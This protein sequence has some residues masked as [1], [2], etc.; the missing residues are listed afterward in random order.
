MD[1][2]MHVCMYVCMCMYVYLYIQ[3][4]E[5][6]PITYIYVYIYMCVYIHIPIFLH[7]CMYVYIYVYIHTYDPGF[8][9]L[10]RVREVKSDNSH[11]F[12]AAAGRH[13]WLSLFLAGQGHDTRS[14]RHFGQ[15]R[16]AIFVTVVVSGRS[17][18]RSS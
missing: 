8:P 6:M 14:C 7:V 16:V 17:G 1:A 11:R 13:P 3:L 9:A 5:H 2:C 10:P 4:G 12:W 18:S 15:V